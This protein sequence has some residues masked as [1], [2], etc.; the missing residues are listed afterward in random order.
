MKGPGYTVND[1]AF[2]T[3]FIAGT[4]CTYMV[5]KSLPAFTDVLQQLNLGDWAQIIALISSVLV[6]AAL[7]AAA[8]RTVRSFDKPK[9][10]TDEPQDRE[11][12][13]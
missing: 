7:G 5:L 2:W 10:P 8:E 1:L 12:R 13:P 3:G 11:P 9:Q 6:G 4:S